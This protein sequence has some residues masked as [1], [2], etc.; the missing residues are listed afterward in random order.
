MHVRNLEENVAARPRSAST[1]R[2]AMPVDV[3]ECAAIDERLHLIRGQKIMRETHFDG[4]HRV[5]ALYH[6]VFE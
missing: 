1:Q 2:S 5:E 6:F 3:F 4:A